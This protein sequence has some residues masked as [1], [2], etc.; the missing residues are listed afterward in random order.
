MVSLAFFCSRGIGRPRFRPFNTRVKRLLRVPI[1]IKTIW[2]TSED[3]RSSH[4]SIDKVGH[5]GTFRFSF[6][7]ENNSRLHFYIVSDFSNC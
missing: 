1:Q 4:L 7:L 3:K 5:K 2:A 6:P